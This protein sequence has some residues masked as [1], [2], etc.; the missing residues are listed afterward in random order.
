MIDLVHGA[1]RY[2]GYIWPAYGVSLGGVAVMVV[3]AAS[4]A[5]RWRREAEKRRGGLSPNDLDDR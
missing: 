4:R 3:Y 1:G 2:G 5:V